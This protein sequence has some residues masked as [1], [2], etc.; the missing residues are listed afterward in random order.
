MFPFYSNALIS[1]AGKKTTSSIKISWSETLS[2]ANNS[3][4]FVVAV[5]N[6]SYFDDHDAFLPE[7]LCIMRNRG[8]WCEQSFKTATFP[9]VQTNM[10]VAI[11]LRICWFE[12]LSGKAG[13]LSACF[14]WYWFG[15][16]LMSKYW[17]IN[18]LSNQ[19]TE[20]SMLRIWWAIDEQLRRNQ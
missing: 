8:N 20:Q 16:H 4:G 14:L 1:G 18:A 10:I 5:A 7:C 9:T 13:I 3:D 17:A 15:V 19:C 12:G 2:F 6:V 11:Y